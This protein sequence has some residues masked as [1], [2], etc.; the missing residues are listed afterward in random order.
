MHF[1]IRFRSVSIL[2]IKRRYQQLFI[3]C[4]NRKITPPSCLFAYS[5]LAEWPQ[6]NEGL[7]AKH[8]ATE[9][10]SSVMKMSSNIARADLGY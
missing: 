3:F 2:V 7:Q 10:V 5:C 9:H 8:S 6:E 4:L 1:W